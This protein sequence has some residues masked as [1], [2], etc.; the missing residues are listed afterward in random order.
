MET[1]EKVLSR[2]AKTRK[3]K[4]LSQENMAVELGISQAA[5]TN[6]ENNE[7]KLTVERLLKIAA[8]LKKPVYHFFEVNPNKVYN[9]NLYESSVGYQQDIEN[10]FQDNKNVYDKLEKSYKETITTLKDENIFLKSLLK[11]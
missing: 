5:Y 10:L 11:K 1:I 4:G 2:I 6:M 9:Q 8:I 3:Q 7:S